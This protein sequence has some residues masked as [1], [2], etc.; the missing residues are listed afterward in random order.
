MPCIEKIQKREVCD[1]LRVL[2]EELKMGLDALITQHDIAHI[3][4]VSGHPC[5]L[6]LVFKDAQPYN[7]WHVRTLFMQEVLRRGILIIGTHNL[8]YA[9]TKLD[10][11]CLLAVYDEVFPII[12][13]AVD[14]EKMPELL[15][16]EVLEPLF[17]LR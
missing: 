17:A 13:K 14:Q 8:S 5:W 1:Y 3:I 11:Q 7:Q 15:E 6:F 10:I 16:T 9:H 2:G 12:K 4:A